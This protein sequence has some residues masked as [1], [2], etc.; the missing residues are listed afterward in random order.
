MHAMQ[1][2]RVISPGVVREIILT[3]FRRA[4]E[5]SQKMGRGPYGPPTYLM[6][7]KWF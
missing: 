3:L 1:G 6:I 5:D 7:G 2:P 4:F